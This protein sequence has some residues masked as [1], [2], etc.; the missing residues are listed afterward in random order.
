MENDTDFKEHSI[1]LTTEYLE[2]YPDAASQYC[3][4]KEKQIANIEKNFNK[5]ISPGDPTTKPDILV[6]EVLESLFDYDVSKRE[7]I[8]KQYNDQKQTE[9]MIGELL[10]RYIAKEGEIY[11]WAFSGECIK[12]VDFIKKDGDK[13]IKLQ[14]K[15]SD[16]TENSSAKAIRDDTPIIKWF[17]RFSSPKTK[18]PVLKKNG[19][20]AKT[21]LT[22][23]EYEKILE[24]GN[25]NTFTQPDYNWENFP[26]DDLVKVLSEEGFR[27]FI[28][29]HIETIKSDL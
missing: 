2:K 1:K 6:S 29:K 13:W 7:E 22:P 17:R 11:G 24:T 14:I 4:T 27:E 28:N 25:Y 9:M 26:D 8:Q 21:G 3:K 12:A 10:E 19:E 20:L 15:T 5:I 16:N 18:T 23:K